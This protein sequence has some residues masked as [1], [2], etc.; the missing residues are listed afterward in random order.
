MSAMLADIGGQPVLILKEGTRRERGK[1]VL[2]NNILAARIL[3]EAIRTSLGPRGMDKMLVDSLGDVTVTNDGAT[4]LDEIEVEHPA[5]KI[6]VEVAK[7]QDDECGDGTTSAVVLA[8]E[9]LRRAEKLLEHDI[10]PTII[11]SGLKMAAKKAV[12]TLEKIARPISINDDELLKKVAMTSMSSKTIAGAKEYLAEIC[13]KA[14]KSIAEERD[15]KWVADIDQIQI[16]KKE[17]KSIFETKLYNGVIID[18]EV[19]HPGMPKRIENAK[20]ALINAPLEIEKTEFDAEIRITDPEQVKAFL[21]EEERMLLNMVEKIAKTG[22]NVV[23]CQ[24]GI[25]DLAQYY[26][27]KKGILAVRR[28]KKSDMEKLAR[29]T[30]ADIVTNIDELS[31]EHLGSAELVEERK[32]GEDKMVFILGCKNPKSVSILIRGGLERV[33]DEAERGIHDALSVVADCIEVGKIVPGGGASE[34]EMALAVRKY[35]DS[36][37]G[38]ERW[39]VEEFAE[40]LEIVPKALA[41]NAGLDP[42]EIVMDLRRYHKEGKKAYGVEIF[43]GECMDM[44]EAGVIE[45]FN[46][47]KYVVES[48]VEAASMILRVDEIIAA[49]KAKPPKGKEGEEEVPEEF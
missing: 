23:F 40:A 19:V 29:A 49:A 42:I 20:I 1:E 17:G 16:V 48:A 30:G 41:E 28:V 7:A 27:A 13:V 12:E 35:A 11:V 3:A 4:I 39:A 15:G 2:K 33:I 24:K 37:K 36:V 46:V 38:R 43:S 6:L 34:I 21:E 32:V 9:I 22:A 10:H 45:P 25:D 18:K 8:G 47:K 31:P 14:V 26:L 44:F 5:A